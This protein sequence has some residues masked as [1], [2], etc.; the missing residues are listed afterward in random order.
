VRRPRALVAIALAL[1]ALAL[2]L[3][4]SGGGEEET[5]S[6]P[7]PSNGVQAPSEG[8]T[9]PSPGALPPQLVQC[10]VDQ[11]FDVQSPADI[12]SAPPQVVEACFG[13]LHQGGGA[14]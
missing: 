3:A 12:H 1:V 2:L 4:V 14:P 8:A 10:F 7:A 6:S 9:P 5:S 11:G 13:S